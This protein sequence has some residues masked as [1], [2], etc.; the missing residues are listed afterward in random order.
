MPN[1]RCFVG[2]DA[3]VLDETFFLRSDS[4][5]IPR[6][7]L[8]HKVTAIETSVDVTGTGEFECLESRNISECGD[9]L[10]R[11]FARRLTQALRKFEG[12]WQ[13]K[14]AKRNLWR[15]FD[16]NIRKF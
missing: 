1:V 13:R 9:Y 11:G 2:I 16:Y 4:A 5:S 12:Q 15:L 3:R 10:L 8:P 6:Q 7:H 14:F